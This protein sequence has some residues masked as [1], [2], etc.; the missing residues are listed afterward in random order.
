M[1]EEYNRDI[2]EKLIALT[3]EGKLEWKEFTP[4]LGVFEQYNDLYFTHIYSDQPLF[5]MKFIF[6]A[7]V[8]K[9]LM[10]HPTRSSEHYSVGTSEKIGELIR[11]DTNATIGEVLTR[12]A[13]VLDE[14]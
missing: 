10:R 9:V 13:G 4:A 5:S 14:L 11:K 7:D 8:D 2:I 1:L 12:I 6:V 3:E